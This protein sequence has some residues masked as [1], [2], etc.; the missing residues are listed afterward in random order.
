MN[1]YMS[2]LQQIDNEI[3]GLESCLVSWR[4]SLGRGDWHYKPGYWFR[5]TGTGFGQEEMSESEMSFYDS[6]SDVYEF[7]LQEKKNVLNLYLE[8]I[9]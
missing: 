6:I 5:A 3:E 7:L 9:L 4:Q 2:K 8:S 1:G